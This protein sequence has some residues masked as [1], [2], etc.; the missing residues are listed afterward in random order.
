MAT[1]D[2]KRQS[3]GSRVATPK[4]GSQGPGDFDNA[5]PKAVGAR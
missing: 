1:N 4:L 5:L 2:V 3:V